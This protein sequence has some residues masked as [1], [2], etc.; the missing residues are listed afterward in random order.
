MHTFIVMAGGALIFGFGVMIG[1]L[2]NEMGHH[3]EKSSDRSIE[4]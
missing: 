1:G 2:L 3:A 4:L